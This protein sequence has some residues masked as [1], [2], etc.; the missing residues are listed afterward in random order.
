MNDPKRKKKPNVNLKVVTQS[1]KIDA[2][3]TISGHGM[4]DGQVSK[5]RC[6][7]PAY[8]CYEHACQKRIPL[9]FSCMC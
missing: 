3:N 2:W 8:N 4:Q 5:Y 1:V 7:M 6:K 9:W